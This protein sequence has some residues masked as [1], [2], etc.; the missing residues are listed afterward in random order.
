[1][2]V[3]SPVV[4]PGPTQN[5]TDPDVVPRRARPGLALAVRTAVVVGP[6]ALALVVGA[7]AALVVPP[8]RVGLPVWL[9]LVSV[10]VVTSVVLF[11]CSRLLRRLAPLSALLRLSLVLPDDVP[12]RFA[13]ARRRWS[14]E[15]LEGSERGG[16][17]SGQRVLALVATLA[18]HDGRTRAHAERVQAYA[19]L[20][21][22]EM[23][24]SAADVDRLSWAALLHDVGKVHVP[25]EVINKAG[26]PSEAEWAQLQTHPHHGGEL[27]EP[28]RGWLGDWLDGV[29]QHHERFD[30][31]GYPRALAGEDIH[32]AA[33]II[34]VADTY[35][36]ITSARA[37]KKP[38]SA[39]QARAEITRCAGAQFDP[40]VVRALLGVGIAKL[41]R[42]AGP[43]TLLAA[44]PVV[45]AAPA[46]AAPS[47]GAALQVAGG[48]AATA[49]LAAGV[50]VTGGVATADVIAAPPGA[51]V[52]V[53][54]QST[55]PLTAN[56]AA[57]AP[58][59]RA[60][61]ASGAIAGA[62]SVPTQ[63]EA[64]GAPSTPTSGPNALPSAVEATAAVPTASTTAAPLP[65]A[66]P[67]E[68][69]PV[70]TDPQHPAGPSSPAGNRPTL[71]VTPPSTAAPRTS[72]A[73]VLAPSAPRPADPRASKVPAATSAPARKA[74]EEAKAAA[75]K[76][77]K[78]KADQAKAAADPADAAGTAAEQAARKAAKDAADAASRAAKQADDSASRLTGGLTGGLVSGRTDPPP[79]SSSGSSGSSGGSSS[80]ASRAPE[81]SQTAVTGLPGAGGPVGGLVT[82]RR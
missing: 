64:S 7:V 11:A 10:V 52:L 68:G 32:L 20:I 47:V 78:G 6:L 17:G 65:T 23:G 57:A 71:P 63:P 1:S 31:T 75:E 27:V 77:A 48:H 33:R 24:L 5:Y 29:E 12:H 14:P 41:R 50:G 42:V 51:A 44:L 69:A 15:A 8:A 13:L 40:V 35:D 66:S 2:P 3:V 25:V 53:V 55:V 76:A 22:Q 79:K 70:A 28:L 73:P 58:G 54:Q 60:R 81:R 72:P 80:G 56:G 36:V 19:A 74:A 49:V 9:W 21:G 18:A 39:E 45:V 38:M 59:S 67:L 34:A 4:S 43:A 26:R 82:G 16:E 46:Q 37:Y 61:S 30:G 62:T